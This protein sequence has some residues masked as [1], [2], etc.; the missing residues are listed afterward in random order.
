MIRQRAC[1]IFA[2][3][4]NRFRAWVGQASAFLK[5]HNP[6]RTD[7]ASKNRYRGRSY[8]PAA[9]RGSAGALAVVLCLVTLSAAGLTPVQDS[10]STGSSVEILEDD[11]DPHLAAPA[12]TDPTPSSNTTRSSIQ[13]DAAPSGD[14]ESGL[15]LSRGDTAEATGP[16]PTPT[17]TPAPS[18]TPTPIVYPTTY[19]VKSGDTVWGV[20]EA[21]YGSSDFISLI[22]YA[23]GLPYTNPVLYSGQV[24]EILDPSTSVPAPTPAPVVVTP[25]TSVGSVAGYS[26]EDID[27]YLHIVAA[28]A[29]AG[30]S[31]EGVL[32]VAQVIVN[33]VHNGRW[34]DLRGVLTAPNQFAPYT[35]GV[36]RYA[37]ANETERRAALDALNGATIFGRDVLYFCTEGA[38]AKSTWF[39]S[40]PVAAQYANTLFFNP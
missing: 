31:Y 23:N 32:M 33:R 22:S 13:A 1:A 10:E 14:P 19:Q 18:P 8:L 24:L 25:G 3:V 27:L 30:W 12:P 21:M 11:E 16:E 9:V 39:Q 29:G 36:Y 35:T 2:N 5:G 40:L 17:A 7:S 28:E 26:A 15:I 38:Y 20:A 4:W 6:F 37:A 34:G